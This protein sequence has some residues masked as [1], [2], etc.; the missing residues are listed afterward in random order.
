MKNSLRFIV[1]L[2]GLFVFFGVQTSLAQVIISEVDP[3]SGMIE[4]HN[5]GDDAVDVS[6]MF[7]CNRPAYASLA[8]LEIV[9]GDLTLEGHAYVVLKWA[10]VASNDAE[11][12]LYSRPSYSSAEA[13][14]DYIAWGSA[15]HGR[16]GVAVEAG[17]WQA[18]DFLAVPTEGMSLTYVGM[19]E[20]L[21]DN[22]QMLEP[23]FGMGNEESAM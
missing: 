2:L 19:A 10:S 14:V 7:F 13:I 6:T 15:G 16:E 21:L 20:N 5:T 8:N 3:S 18:G 12:G 11:L 22:W 4:L 1:M 23:S 17:L 9:S